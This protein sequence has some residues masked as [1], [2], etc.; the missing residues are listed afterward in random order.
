MLLLYK[1]GETENYGYYIVKRG[2]N[3]GSPDPVE[4]GFLAGYVGIRKCVIF[5]PS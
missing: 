1:R 5:I 2:E 4:K 3:T